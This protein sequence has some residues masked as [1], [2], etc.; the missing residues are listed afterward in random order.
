LTEKKANKTHDGARKLLSEISSFTTVPRKK[1]F[2]VLLQIPLRKTFKRK[3]TK[4]K[5]KEKAVGKKTFWKVPSHGILNQIH[6]FY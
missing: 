4:K 3:K 1:L 6:T 5:T 2:E